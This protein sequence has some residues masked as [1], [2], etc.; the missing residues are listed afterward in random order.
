MS[1]EKWP[2]AGVY[3]AHDHMDRPEDFARDLQGG[4]SGKILHMVVDA[5][6]DAPTREQYDRSA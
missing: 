3:L 1:L 2:P 5:W 4:V 6:I